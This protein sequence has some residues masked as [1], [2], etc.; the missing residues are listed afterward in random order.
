MFRLSQGQLNLLETCPRKFQ[1]SYLEQLAAPATPEQQASMAWGKRFHLLMQQRELGLPVESLISKEA[2]LG[3]CLESLRTAV[4]EI[5]TTA[6]STSQTFR[7]SE[8]CRTLKIGGY[9]L[10]VVYD[11]LILDDLDAQV[12]DWKTYPRPQNP[13]RLGKNWQT[14]L[15]PFVLAE[16]SEYLP[17]QISMTY[18]FVQSQASQTDK[19]EP[20]SLKFAYS[21]AQHQRTKAILSKLL[22]QVTDWLQ[23]YQAGIPFPQVPETSPLCKSCQFAVRC[24]RTKGPLSASRHHLLS[25]AEIPEV[26]MCDASHIAL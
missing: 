17:E 22:R 2:E 15:Y 12:L 11:L 26:S 20:Q 14:R 4:P 13:A 19:P 8:H 5:F 9:L 1:Y 25:L 24:Q 3:R 16:T 23:D 18:W 21:E 10:T 7:E 6:L